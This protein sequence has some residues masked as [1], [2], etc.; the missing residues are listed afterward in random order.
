MHHDASA[1]EPQSSSLTPPPVPTT[2]GQSRRA[3]TAVALARPARRPSS[4]LLQPA[5][6][7][8]SPCTRCAPDRGPPAAHRCW[9]NSMEEDSMPVTIRAHF[10]GRVIVPDEPVEL[11]VGEPLEVELK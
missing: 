2:A 4:R 1:G 6:P 11:P 3:R 9:Y 10:D 7:P 5:R 8:R